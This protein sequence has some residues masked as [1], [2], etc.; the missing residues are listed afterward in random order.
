MDSKTKEILQK[1]STQKVDLANIKDF[2]TKM[3]TFDKSV[4]NF[5]SDIVDIVNVR[6]A[7]RKKYT[8]LV[9]DFSDLDKEY[10]QFRRAVLDLGVDMPQKIETDYKIA[11]QILKQSTN[12]YKELVK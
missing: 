4:Q 10:D 1:F 2:K 11:L 5:T 3:K 6:E 7:A 8:K 9:D 12:D